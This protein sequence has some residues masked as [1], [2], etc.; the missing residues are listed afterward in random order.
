MVTRPRLFAAI[1]SLAAATSLT[2]AGLTAA[3]TPPAQAAD[4][5]T[6]TVMNN[7]PDYPN[8]EVWVSATGVG[9]T[10]PEQALHDRDTFVL[11]NIS[12]GRV[13]VSLGDPINSETFPSPDTSPLRFDT[14]EL[15]YPGVANLTAVDMFAIPMDIETFDADGNP[16]AAK[17]WACY[18]DVVQ[19]GV[20][21]RLTE[22]GGD[23]EK[24]VRTDEQGSFLRLVSPNIVSGLHPSGYPRFDA[25]LESLIN[26]PLT[27]RGTAMGK[28]YLYTGAFTIDPEHPNDP[29]SLTL[30]DEGPDQLDPIHVTGASLIGNSSNTENGIY[31]NNAPYTVGGI[32]HSGNDVYG[33]VYRDLV[34]GFAYGFWGNGAYGN[35]SANFNVSNPPGPFEDAQPTYPYYNVWAAALWPL[36][37]A[38]GFPYGDT[39][40]HDPARN[41]IVELPTNGTLRITINPDVSPDSCFTPNSAPTPTP[42]NTPS[43]TPTPTETPTASESSPPSSAPPS[44]STIP[45]ATPPVTTSPTPPASPTPSQSLAPT[46]TVSPSPSP[47]P[48][49][50]TPA[51]KTEQSVRD[52]PNRMKRGKRVTLPTSTTQGQ[53]LK[54]TAKSKRVCAVKK[55]KVRA[56]ATGSCRL[57]ATAPGTNTLLAFRGKFTIKVGG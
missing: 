24:V 49:N 2:I 8:S 22:A 1:A 52:I 57:A 3:N 19:E 9:T 54:W 26:V 6:V 12:S 35:D 44:Q 56:R 48:P 39:Y 23:Y 34:A 5:L 21:S 33:A 37:D 47:S 31:G 4:G 17:K 41:P 7:N 50:P 42:T 28:T 18:T 29:A 11:P 15:T 30:T 20:N 16:L 40:N 10:A 27:I 43:F 25:Y 55:V 38:Y 32:P 13:W 53:P 14:V 46:P 51:V 45:T 36:T